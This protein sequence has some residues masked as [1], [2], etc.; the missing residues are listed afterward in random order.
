MQCLVHCPLLHLIT[1]Y[2]LMVYYLYMRVC[3][4]LPKYTE[5]HVILNESYASR[6]KFTLV[7]LIQ[8]CQQFECGRI[9]HI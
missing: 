7:L 3:P 9:I 1:K 8:Y 4:L 2:K 5:M 6:N